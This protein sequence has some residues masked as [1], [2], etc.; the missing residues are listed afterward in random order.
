[1]TLM[2]IEQNEIAKYQHQAWG[3]R[4]MKLGRTFHLDENCNKEAEIFTSRKHDMDYFTVDGVILRT[5]YR[6][7]IDWYLLPLRESLDNGADFLW[8]HYKGANDASIAVNITM[9]DKLFRMTVRNSND[10]N[11]SV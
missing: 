2:N 9:D 10:K 11:I 8:N 6:D 1:M 4:K 5:G 3:Y 7:K